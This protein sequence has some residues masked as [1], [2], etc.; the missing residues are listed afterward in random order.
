MNT[1]IYSPSGSNAGIGFAVPA[2]TI[3]RIVPEI[4]RTGRYQR[5]GLGVNVATD[6]FARGMGVSEGV[7][8]VRTR[9]GSAGQ[10]AGLR[11]CAVNAQGRV[12]QIGDVIIKVNQHR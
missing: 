8:V 5:P 6:S 11:P 2:D 9:V 12:T 1:A 10:R 4:V 7:L 3:K